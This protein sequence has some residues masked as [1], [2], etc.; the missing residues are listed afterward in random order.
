MALAFPGRA[1]RCR[2]VTGFLPLLVAL[3]LVETGWRAGL[4]ASPAAVAWGVAGGLALWLLLCETA[5]RLLDRWRPARGLER[6]DA[7]AQVL[8]LAGFAWICLGLGWPRRA[9]SYT[10]ALLPWALAM[11]AHWWTMAH[12]SRGRWSRLGHLWHQVRFALL[13]VAVALPVL[14]LCDRF[15]EATGFT[16]WSF[17][18]LGPASAVLGSLGLAALLV[19]GLPWVLVRLWRAEPMPDGELRAAFAEACQRCRV[20][21]GGLLVWPTR[22]GRFHNAMVLGVLPPLRYVLVTADLLH[23]F[24]RDQLMAVLG[25]ELGHARHRHLWLF[26]LFAAVVAMATWVL[27]PLLAL[28]LHALPLP[29]TLPPAVAEGAVAVAMLAL[30]WRLAFGVLSRL[31]ERQ[32]DLSGAQLVGD[33]WIMQDALAMVGRLSGQAQDAPSW[34]HYTLGQRIAW[35]ERLRI[36]PAEAGRHHRRVA[37]AWWTLG[38]TALGLLAAL[39]LR[40]D[41]RF[42]GS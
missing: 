13:P 4:A 37:F 2:P 38:G 32:A 28:H 17:T 23:D 6:W 9:G 1:L 36:D 11:A 40:G 41:L 19:A 25:H 15:G 39:L 3:V 24:T 12:V 21:V 16:A 34:R 18:H 30:W 8:A 33:P 14:D 42:G 7:A 31:C 26:L 27:A 5:V 20:G 35:L 29:A 10:V 22:G